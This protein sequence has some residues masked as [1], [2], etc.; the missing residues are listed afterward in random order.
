ML[1]QTV[2]WLAGM[3][4]VLF[5]GAGTLAWREGWWFLLEMG[6][7]GLWIGLWLARY[8]PGLLAER[9]SP[10]VQRDQSRWD[11]LFMMS[12]AVGWT[13][14]MVL[15]ACDAVR[16]RWS[17]MPASLEA[18][19]AVCMAIAYYIWYLVFRTNSFAAP[20]IKIQSERGHKVIDTGPYA[21]V[22]H[23]MYSGAVLFFVGTALLLGSWWGLACVPVLVV[24]L[25][26]RAVEEERTLTARLEGYP[27]YVQRV[28]Y[29][30]MPYVW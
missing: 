12:V 5:V 18:F 16:F 20:V 3:A 19:G 15:I 24:A 2:I 8:D 6:V 28:R 14:W 30:L 29:R 4:A 17:S 1:I 10:I 26:R 25:S 23:P 13:L 11:K 7:L 21:F 9:L 27:Q 22:R